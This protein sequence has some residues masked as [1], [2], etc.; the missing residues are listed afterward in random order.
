MIK[1]EK[2][3]FDLVVI[4]DGLAGFLLL[5]ELSKYPGFARQKI[6]LLGDGQEKHRTWCF[7][8]KSLEPAFQNMVLTSWKK[9]SFKSNS[10]DICQD[11]GALNYYYIPGKAFF[12]YFMKEFL[13]EHT[14]IRYL[15]DRAI[16]ISGSQG[17]FRVM[18]EHGV[19]EATNVYNS[20]FLGLKPQIGIW[21]HFR[22]WFI[23][24]DEAVFDTGNALMMD[25]SIAQKGD[26]RFMYVLPLSEKKALIELTYFGPR[27]LDMEDYDKDIALYISERFGVK[28]K[29]LEKEYGQIPM[30]QGVFHHSGMKGEINIGTLA[31]MVKASTGFAFQ[32]IFR[33]S[34]ELAYAYFTGKKPHRFTEKDRFGFYDSLLLWVIRNNPQS[35]NRIFSRLFQ[36]RKMELILRFMDQKTSI[37]EELKIFVSLPSGIFLEAFFYRIAGKIFPKPEY[38]PPISLRLTK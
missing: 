20:A 13:P 14:Q 36:H 33:D 11:L 7:W 38:K 9:L 16:E 8:D 5:Y 32:R 1:Q 27:P 30:Q 15:T 35:G 28:Y 10:V 31:G 4:G 34:K 21:Q 2:S 22:G 17:N 29:I 24:S 18:A 3:I 37:W 12:E 19:Y 6:L 26:C 25:F 23:E